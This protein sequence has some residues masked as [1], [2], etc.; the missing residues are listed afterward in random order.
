MNHFP[1]SSDYI[2]VFVTWDKDLSLATPTIDTGISGF[3]FLTTSSFL[4]SFS[5]F[6]S[7]F[8]CLFV[9]FFIFNER[10]SST[11]QAQP[12]V[13]VVLCNVLHVEDR[14][15]TAVIQSRGLSEYRRISLGLVPVE[16]FSATR[17]G[18]IAAGINKWLAV[19]NSIHDPGTLSD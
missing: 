8:I 13:C 14:D 15:V 6:S 3:F 5:F 7:P 2:L 17:G 4:P 12:T 9:Y 19:G 18:G 11:C 10:L 1:F 16:E